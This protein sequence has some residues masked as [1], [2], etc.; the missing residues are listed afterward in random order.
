MPD[1][2]ESGPPKRGRGRPRREGA[3]EEILAVARELLRTLGYRDVTVDAVTERTGI[4]KTTI[5]RRWPTKPALIGAALA[6][7]P[8]DAPPPAATLEDDLVA[9][10]EQLRARIELV[11]GEPELREAVL[12]RA[13]FDAAIDRAVARGE[14]GA[15]VDRELVID[16]LTSPLWLR[17]ERRDELSTMI[18]RAVLN[19]IRHR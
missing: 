7:E 1:D 11:D 15:T 19:G 12:Q 5:Y 14:L 6:A 10:L 8:I 13:S 16:L 9:L 4:A 17:R 3:D 18:V 2:A